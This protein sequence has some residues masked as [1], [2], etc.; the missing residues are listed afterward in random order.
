MKA[1]L[2]EASWSPKPGYKPTPVEQ[3]TRRT[4][5]SSKMWRNPKLKLVEAEKPKPKPDEVLVRVEASGVCGS[6]VHMIQPDGEGYMLYP[7]L[8]KLPVIIGHE[9]SGVVEE[10]GSSVTQFQPGEPVTAEE[11]W[12]CGR[13]LHC[14][15]GMFNQCLNLEEM[16]FTVD[17]THAEYVAVPEKYVWSLKPIQQNLKITEDKLFELGAT[18]EPTSV[19]Y[20]AMFVRAGG[21]PPGGYVAVYGAGPIGLAAT[22]LAKAAGAS[23]VIVFDLIEERLTLARSMGADYTFNVDTLRRQ[24]VTPSEKILEATEGYGADLQVEAAGAPDVLLPE[25][26]KALA[27][28]GRV[29]WIGRADKPAQIYLENLQVKA[30]QIYGSQGHSGNLIFYNVIRMIASGRIDP[31]RMVTARYKLEE[32]EKAFKEL[33]YSKKHGKIQFKP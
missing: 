15:G 1:L 27:V 13:C 32:Y 6:D 11:M 28:G 12:W 17:G 29:A 10:V 20:N 33:I 21:F 23:K 31:G 30:S 19:A 2:L 25:I 7:G 5:R 3:E 22:A 24:D 4:H 14:R 26:E 18:V 16:G 8:T 9:F